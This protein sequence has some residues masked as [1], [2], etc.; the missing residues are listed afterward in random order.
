MHVCSTLLITYCR[1]WILYTVEMYCNFYQMNC[2]K[3]TSC[4]NLVW[5]CFENQP[6]KLWSLIPYSIN[7]Q[8]NWAGVTIT[9]QSGNSVLPRRYND[10]LLHCQC[11]K[12]TPRWARTCDF[13]YN[14]HITWNY[15]VSITLLMIVEKYTAHKMITREG[16]WKL[17]PK[18]G[19]YGI[20]R[21]GIPLYSHPTIGISHLPNS[22]L[23]WHP[24]YS[25]MP[26]LGS[27]PTKE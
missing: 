25:M 4:P 10:E 23:E 22:I 3:V 14:T 20:C 12:P 1:T 11:Q 9:S 7:R 2:F 19:S 13:I 5:L 24:L 16:Q 21:L 26:K 15:C 6:Q 8:L 27:Y 18:D 17:Q